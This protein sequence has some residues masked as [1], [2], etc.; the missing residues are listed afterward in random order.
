MKPNSYHI[1]TEIATAT[2]PGQ[3]EFDNN[4]YIL[5][6]MGNH[7]LSTL[8][9]LE[10]VHQLFMCSSMIPPVFLPETFGESTR[11]YEKTH[12]VVY[13]YIMSPKSVRE[14]YINKYNNEMLWRDGGKRYIC[15]FNVD[16][17]TA[18]FKT[19]CLL[20]CIPARLIKF[21]WS[22][23]VDLRD[24]MLRK[25]DETMLR[26]GTATFLN[27]MDMFNREHIISASERMDLEK[28]KFRYLPKE[29]FALI[30]R[31]L[32]WQDVVSLMRCSADTFVYISLECYSSILD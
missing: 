24:H 27:S 21:A 19:A 29:I 31:K 10:M 9:K 6:E 28:T 13:V 15:N 17:V 26:Y 20:R 11:H 4:K 1:S 3:I 14:K 22:H 23:D 32:K 2:Q 12:D 30:L 5:F 8:S 18:Y 7:P 25:Y 16:N